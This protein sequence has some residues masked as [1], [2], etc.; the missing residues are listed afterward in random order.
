MIGCSE[1]LGLEQMV[2]CPTRGDNTLDLLFTTHPSLVEKI[3]PLPP[4]GKSDHDIVLCDT[5]IRPTR[6]KSPRRK[7]ILW[8]NADVN[9]IKTELQSFGS[10]FNKQHTDK[11]INNM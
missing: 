10:D 1:D 3:K 7:V 5:D 11:D 6:S 2:Q 8:K 4:I 9:K